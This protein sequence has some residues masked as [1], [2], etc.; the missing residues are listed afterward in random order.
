MAEKLTFSQR[1]LNAQKELKSPKGQYNSLP[2]VDIL[3]N[4]KNI[5]LK[6]PGIYAIYNDLGQVYVGSSVNVRRRIRQHASLYQNN[7]I[8]LF[9]SLNKH[10]IER[11]NF[12]I[13]EYCEIEELLTKERFWGDY[14]NVL[15]RDKGLTLVLPGYGEI[16]K[17]V[18]EETRKRIGD[19][20]KNKKLSDCHKKA[21]TTYWI[22]KKQ[23]KDHIE[24]RKMFGEDNPA[25]GNTYFKGKTHSDI[26]RKKFSENAKKNNLGG[27]NPNA[28]K[29]LDKKE[30]VIYPCA[31]DVSV[32]MNINY[33]TLKAWLQGRNKNDGR[34]EYVE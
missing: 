8:K 4:D 11:H 34:F 14:L 30:N 29:V 1:V 28:K 10:G 18:S 17:S 15:D 31:K 26:N 33:G 13:L 5:I 3:D 7:S 12:I 6:K 32:K 23:T 22:G 24:K 25:F 16:K 9:N 2:L 19:K 21:L 27:G 20:H